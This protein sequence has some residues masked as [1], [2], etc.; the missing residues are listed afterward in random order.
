METK[1]RFTKKSTADGKI[2]ANAIVLGVTVPNGLLVTGTDLQGLKFYT[3]KKDGEVIVNPERI[4]K[5]R[6][7]VKKVDEKLIYYLWVNDSITGESFTVDKLESYPVS[8]LEAIADKAQEFW[9]GI[10]AKKQSQD[11]AE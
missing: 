11:T 8:A 7:S 6:A 10:R 2:N 4:Y 5:L 3:N 9:N 1:I